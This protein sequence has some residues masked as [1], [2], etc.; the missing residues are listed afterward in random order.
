VIGGTTAGAGNTIAGNLVGVGITDSGTSGNLVQGNFIGT[1]ASSAAGLGNSQQGVFILNDASE[2]T[3]GG[4]SAGAGNVIAFNG[5]AGVV[6]GNNASST[7]SGDAI[8][9]N[10]IFANAHAGIDLGDDGV[11]AN[12][13]G[14]P[15]SGPNQR[16]NFPVITLAI[17]SGGSIV[18][19]GTL[20]S[21]PSTT[22]TLEFFAN[23]SPDPTGFG[24]GQQLLGEIST[25]T[26]SSGNASF[27]TPG[28]SAPALV[29]RIITATATDPAGNTSEFSQDVLAIAANSAPTLDPIA[30]PAPIAENAGP[31]TVHLTGISTGAVAAQTLSVAASSSNLAL[32]SSPT[33][34]YT[35]PSATGTLSYTPV[36]NASGTATITVFVTSSG[37]SISRAFAVTV[38]PAVETTASHQFISTAEKQVFLGL[39]TAY[40]QRAARL[41]AIATKIGSPLQTP[42]NGLA[43]Y[44][45]DESQ[46]YSA[47]ANDPPDTNFTTV[48]QPQNATLAPVSAGTGITEGE[49]DAFNA[50]FAEQAQALGL[51]Q[52][53]STALDRAQAAA[54]N[55]A[56]AT[57]EQMQLAAVTQFS[58]QLGAVIAS[59][60]QLEANVQMAL[61]AGGVADVSVSPADIQNLQNAGLPAGLSGALNQLASSD[62]QLQSI[63]LQDI[64]AQLAAQNTAAAA[65]SL[66]ATLTDPAFATQVQDAAQALMATVLLTGGLSPASDSG[67][68][69]S[70]GSHTNHATPT[71]IG[72]APAGTTV[73]IFAQRPVDSTPVLIGS[74]VTDGTGHWQITAN[75][76]DDGAYAISAS[77]SGGASGSGQVTPLTQVVIETVAPRITGASYSKKTGKVTIT[78]DDAAGIDP[79]SLA[80]A[81]FFVARPGKGAKKQAVKVSGFQR[82]GTQVTFT[83]AQGRT[84]PTAISLEV[85]AGGVQD[86]AG[87]GLDGAFTGTF[88]SGN[89]HPGSNFFTQLPIP[90]HKRAKLTKA[91]HKGK[92]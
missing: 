54:T 67:V 81:A 17:R 3:I 40:A 12:T 13:S 89:G 47:L 51:A 18:I 86:L 37:G 71:F 72:T 48:A 29:G 61:T 84:H 43:A 15:H 59:E 22:F 57:F 85:V 49:A 79:A 68:T 64:Q 23:P 50:L 77:F 6:V 82:S 73:Q 1:S 35:S 26:D 28:L 5:G 32:I 80:N 92:A 87:N 25:T 90:P 69:N 52:A 83:V 45:W 8:L 38:T 76:L 20:N 44:Y 34:T 65:G 55:P 62:L 60:P 36:A 75:H 63:P 24:Q 41:T 27:T 58:Q 53:I 14:G 91:P 9:A 2:N 21:T 11:T 19:G 10:S 46:T 42:I 16:Q 56:D 78:F 88:P 4:Q 7:E 74:G 30:N 31:Q 33:V 70:A 39:A 66:F